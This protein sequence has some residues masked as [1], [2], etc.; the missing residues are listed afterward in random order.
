MD[1]MISQYDDQFMQMY[2]CIFL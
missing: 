1:Y 2:N